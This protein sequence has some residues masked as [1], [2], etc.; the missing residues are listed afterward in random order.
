MEYTMKKSIKKEKTEDSFLNTK[1]QNNRVQHE[2]RTPAKKHGRIMI[3][4]LRHSFLAQQ[5]YNE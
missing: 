3:F 2:H 1:Q 4:P 5:G